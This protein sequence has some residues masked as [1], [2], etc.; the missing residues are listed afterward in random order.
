MCSR[1]L[2]CRLHPQCNAVLLSASFILSLK[3]SSALFFLLPTIQSAWAVESMV[4]GA[5]LRP[6]VMEWRAICLSGQPSVRFPKSYWCVSPANEKLAGTLLQ[7]LKWMT[8]LHSKDCRAHSAPD[9]DFSSMSP[10]L[11][12]PACSMLTSSADR[13]ADANSK[14]PAEVS[15]LKTLFLKLK[16]APRGAQRNAFT[17]SPVTCVTQH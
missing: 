9:L 11:W 14:A 7:P 10:F 5:E 3:E 4:S 1:L 15:F 17:L 8:F 13:C 2:I 16:L 12:S 6:W